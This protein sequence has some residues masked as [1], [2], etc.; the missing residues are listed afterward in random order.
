[1][2]LVADEQ[3]RIRTMED[4]AQDYAL[5]LRW[6]TNPTVQEWY[7]NQE[8][9]TLDAIKEKYQPRITGT[10]Y[11]HPAI[12]EWQ[13]K[14]VGYLQYYEA[15]EEKGY[16]LKELLL[17]EPDVWAIDILIGETEHIGKGIGSASLRLMIRYLFEEQRARTIIIDPDTR[18][19]RAIRAYEKAGFKK[20]K[21]LKNWEKHAG[22]WTDAWLMTR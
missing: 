22:K 3:I 11:V 12:I 20:L 15:R 5:L 17:E 4:A 18:N 13:G 2:E 19:E 1:M 6:L 21:V 10:D 16:P 7:E 9:D 8:G 14:P